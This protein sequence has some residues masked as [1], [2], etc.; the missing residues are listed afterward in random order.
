MWSVS[1]RR[2]R[3]SGDL[4]CPARRLTTVGP[5]T[6]QEWRPDRGTLIDLIAI[7]R[8]DHHGVLPRRVQEG[9]DSLMALRRRICED[10]SSLHILH[11]ATRSREPGASSSRR[12]AGRRRGGVERGT[13]TRRTATAMRTLH[14]AKDL[15]SRPSRP[16]GSTG[17]KAEMRM[18]VQIAAERAQEDGGADL[19]VTHPGGVSQL[20]PH[21]GGEPTEPL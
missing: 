15:R 21:G 9:R 12:R 5:T 16:G 18:P 4:R 6:R 3:A 10:R 2:G 19:A 13:E 7:R 8:F 14:E 11:L 17:T 1:A 20:P